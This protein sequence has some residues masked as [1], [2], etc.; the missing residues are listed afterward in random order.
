MGLHAFT[1]PD[2]ENGGFIVRFG[3]LCD[4]CGKEIKDPRDGSI[5]YTCLDPGEAKS[6]KR[7]N[8][9]FGEDRPEEDFLDYIV[10]HTTTCCPKKR[11][12][13]WNYLYKVMHQLNAP[14]T[15]PRKKVH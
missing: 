3:W 8:K 2:P 9:V 5:D 6:N 13:Y 15:K 12:R 10:Y 4:V 7:Y 14:L 1:K 11:H